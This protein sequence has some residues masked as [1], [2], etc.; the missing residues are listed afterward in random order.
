MV[1]SQLIKKLVDREDA[2]VP[3]LFKPGQFHIIKKIN[4]GKKLSD[5]EK[6]YLRGKM[7]QKLMALEELE[8]I[9]RINKSTNIILNEI[10]SYYI[11]GLEALRHNGY[12]W[13]F[14]T[15]II[16]VINTKIEGIIRISGNVFK[17]IRVKSIGT[18]KY[19]IDMKTGLK[20]AAN[21]QIFYDAKI[22]KNEYVKNVWVQMLSRYGKMFVKSHD[23][24]KY[25]LPKE[26]VIDYSKFGV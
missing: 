2:I 14:E 22:T 19:Q 13:Y 26:R 8:G 12:G 11:T 7:R 5:N 16:E 1:N 3:V 20:Y 21:E 4:Q 25:L 18:G 10:E 24:F 6:R 23:K 15:K 17:F 9:E